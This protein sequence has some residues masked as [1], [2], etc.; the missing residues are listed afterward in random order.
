MLKQRKNIKNLEEMEEFADFYVKNLESDKNEAVVVALYGNL[1]SGKTAFVQ[2]VAKIF[3]IKEYITSPTFV[4]QKRYKICLPARRVKN[5]IGGFENLI[6][7]DAY[8]LGTGEELLALGWREIIANP[9]N[10]IFVEWAE[11]VAE[12]LPVCARKLHFKFI[13]DKAREIVWEQ[14]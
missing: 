1:G 12:I 5:V 13:D 3:E 2:C 11:K 7:I 14:K 10:L 9:R 6:H 4:I 8:R